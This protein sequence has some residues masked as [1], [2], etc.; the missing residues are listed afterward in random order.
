MAKEKDYYKT[1][2]VGKNAT[3]E[4]IKAAYKKL[5]KKYHPDLNKS[6]D[7]AEKFKEINEAASV[8]GDQKKRQMYD[9]YGTAGEGCA[10]GSGGFGF[11]DFA[12]FGGMGSAGV[13][14]DE[15]FERFFGGGG[16]GCGH[17]GRERRR[18]R[19]GSDL[20]YELEISLEEAAVGVGKVI[21]IPRLEK[22]AVCEGSG[23][24]S[25][26]SIKDCQDCGGPG[27][28]QRTQRIAFGTFTTTGSCGKCHGS[29][30]II[31]S[32]CKSC[33]GKGRVEK[34]RKIDVKIPAGV[35]TGHR[36]RISGE[37]E[38][39]ETGSASGDLYI[40]IR[41]SPH[42]VFERRGNDIF[43][44]ISIPFATAALG[45]EV[46]VPTLDGKATLKI[47]SGTKGNTLFRMSGKGVPDLDTGEKGSE[48]IRVMIAVPEKLTKRQQELL[49]EFMKEEKS[50]KGVFG[51]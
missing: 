25:R 42:R 23:A 41:V 18:Q 39:G 8:L 21:T 33:H 40:A 11:T 24:E 28:V 19:R 51:G 32:Q 15:L 45:G 17:G 7:A 13:D 1:L 50:G 43:A 22:C 35:D 34:V 29:G 6:H 9:Q 5:A 27:Y 20:V 26:E 36:L 38:A 16:F 3:K 49:R 2:G 37:G 47:P 44:D 48:N 14:I 30:K 31:A 4:G 12:G 46:E 10:A